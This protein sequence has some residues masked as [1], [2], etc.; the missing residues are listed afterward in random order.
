MALYADSTLSFTESTSDACERPAL[1]E[2]RP[3]GARSVS[4][5]DPHTVS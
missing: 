1:L 4:V 5:L 3:L 2:P